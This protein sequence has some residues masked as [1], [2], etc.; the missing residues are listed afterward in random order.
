MGY[1]ISLTQSQKETVS[2][3]IGDRMPK[4]R[5]YNFW[6]L[7]DAILYVLKT[8]CQWNMLPREYPNWRMVYHHFR[9][10]S[11]KGWFG[12]I[13]Q[14]LV[15]RRRIQLGQFPSPVISI[16]DSESVRSC[17]AQ[18]QKGIDGYK[19]VKGI[20]RQVAV[21][22]NGYV[23]AMFA[24][25][26]NVHDSKGVKELISSLL[27]TYKDIVLIKCDMG[28]I[29]I[30]SLLPKEV[31]L[32]CVKSNSGTSGFIPAKGRWVVER[33]FSWMSSYRRLV[34]N[35]EKSLRVASQVFIAA[36]AFFMLRYV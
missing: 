15:K 26:A 1:H 12:E 9:S 19:H 34:R 23:L 10:W 11:E 17:L 36:S 3:I 22:C 29:G 21:D 2:N 5:V 27:A 32:E 33:T 31:E 28:Y 8:G 14:E 16:I 13:L 24:T 25:T 4:L 35:F 20:K 30:G 6:E 7:L 18:S